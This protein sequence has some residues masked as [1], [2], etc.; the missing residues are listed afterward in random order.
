[1]E[2]S[3][4]EVSADTAIGKFSIKS[5]NLNTLATVV[6]LVLS[7]ILLYVVIT[8]T[9][10]ARDASKA[11]VEALKEQTTA[12]REQNCLMRYESRERSERAEFC[13]QISR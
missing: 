10:D 1:M 4:Q 7:G 12:Q 5:A 13:R 6:T 9:V 8:H 2:Q 3:S 11:F